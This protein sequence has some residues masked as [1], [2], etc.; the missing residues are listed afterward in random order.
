MNDLD[1]SESMV[2]PNP[3]VC[4]FLHILRKLWCDS[5]RHLANNMWIDKKA[6]KISR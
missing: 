1:F 2:R 5:G 6:M 3:L 4:R